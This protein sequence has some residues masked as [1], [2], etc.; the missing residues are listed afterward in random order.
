MKAILTSLTLLLLTAP[1]VFSQSYNGPESVEHDDANARYL[2]SNSSNGEIIGRADGTGQLSVFVNGVGAGPHGLEI[3]GNTVYACSGSR[4]KGYDLTSGAEV[5]NINIGGQFLNG[6]TSDG[7]ANLWVTDFS[8]KKVYRIDVATGNYNEM[9]NLNG[10]TGTPNGIIY[11]GN[12]NRL[13][14]VEWGSNA[15]INA[16]ALTDSAVTELVQTNLSNI[17]GIALHD[18]TGYFYTSSWGGNAIH[19]FSNDFT[20]GPSLVSGGMSSPADLHI[21]QASDTLAIPN[22][23]NNTVSFINLGTFVG[24]GSYESKVSFDMYP[25]PTSDV[26]WFDIEM[27]SLEGASVVVM[28]ANGQLVEEYVFEDAFITEYS[29]SID[30]SE[31]EA[32]FYFVQLR[33]RYGNQTRKLVVRK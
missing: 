18:A 15:S 17:D 10:V 32:G 33:S 20:L 7:S 12:N 14:F 23:G 25:N 30:V 5:A 31:Y 27:L 28:N 4:V 6:I 13:V 11:D 24:T 19:S 9:V 21:N 1:T 8:G 29:C 22:S 3:V 2:V 16:I 26:V